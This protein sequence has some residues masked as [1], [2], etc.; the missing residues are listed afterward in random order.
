MFGDKGISNFR[1][2]DPFFHGEASHRAICLTGQLYV[3]TLDVAFRLLFLSV[4][5]QDCDLLLWRFLNVFV[6]QLQI[7]YKNT[8]IQIYR[9]FHLQ[10][11]KIFR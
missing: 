5:E 11:L 9:K 8:P 1:Y 6:S 3:L 2:S 4:L 10:K 7:H